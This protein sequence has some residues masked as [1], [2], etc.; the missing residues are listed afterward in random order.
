MR[1]KII[2]QLGLNV[3]KTAMYKYKPDGQATNYVVI[4]KVPGGVSLNNELV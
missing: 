1:M 2:A 4:A 3:F